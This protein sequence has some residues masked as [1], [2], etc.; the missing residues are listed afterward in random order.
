[1]HYGMKL[2]SIRTN[3]FLPMEKVMPFV[4]DDYYN[5]KHSFYGRLDVLMRNPNPYP[6]IENR[7]QHE[8]HSCGLH[9]TQY[10]AVIYKIITPIY[11]NTYMMIIIEYAVG[12]MN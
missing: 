6:S 9:V 7:M 11:Y 8:K 4:D 10:S 5:N 1:M 3:K 2:F 12:I